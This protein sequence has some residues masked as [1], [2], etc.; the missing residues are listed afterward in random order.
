[1]VATAPD[2]AETSSP[3]DAIDAPEA[4]R[5]DALRR[6]PASALRRLIERYARACRAGVEA[7]PS[8]LSM[9]GGAAVILAVAAFLGGMLRQPFFL[10]NDS[11]Q[12]YAHVWFIEQAIFSGEGLP[13]R[14]PVLE[15][16]RA[17]T[18]PYGVVPWLPA[19]LV[20]PLLGDWAVTASM[21]GG[22]VL[23]I[24]GIWRWLPRTRSPLL[25]AVLLLNPQFLGGLA[26]FQL[27]TFWALAFACLGAAEFSRG[28]AVRGTALATAALYAHPLTGGAALLCTALINAETTRRIPWRQAAGILAAGILAAP[29]VV[30][31]LSTPLVGDVGVLTLVWPILLTLKRLSILGWAWAL[32]R[33]HERAMRWW[34]VI[35]TIALLVIA[36]DFRNV[37]PVGLWEASEPRFPDL[38]AAGRVRPEATYRVL[39]TTNHEDGMVQLLQA[40]AHLG[41][42]FFDESIQRRSFGSVGEY[43]CFLASK[44]VDHVV[45]DDEYV[46]RLGWSDEVPLL[47]RMV[48]EG[49]AT[50]AF[51]GDAGTLEYAL[52]GDAPERCEA[53]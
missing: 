21:V 37:P 52:R 9:V 41:Q 1:M 35:A 50:L 16:G 24:A 4:L 31:C 18:F 22:A 53:R 2:P 44:R 38:I 51:R 32:N 28:R 20:R 3:P 15:S 17:Y 49:T 48:D 6:P 45:V 19:A 10:G 23:L 11:A 30:S 27:P 26:Q 46:T 40:G 12:S 14:M 39:T 42:E 7:R 33:F 47:D 29:V 34:P 8:R 5:R 25:T 13:L 36:N 43:R